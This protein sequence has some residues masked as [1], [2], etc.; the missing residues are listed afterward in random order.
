M[1]LDAISKRIRRI[2]CDISTAI[3]FP[4]CAGRAIGRKIERIG[5]NIV[6]KK[7]NVFR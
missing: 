4:T 6:S 7:L 3:P 5:L 2:I 1:N